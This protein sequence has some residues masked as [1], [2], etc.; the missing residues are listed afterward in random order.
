MSQRSCCMYSSS[1]VSVT[2]THMAPFL[3]IIWIVLSPELGL[4]PN[5]FLS[6]GS[7]LSLSLLKSFSFFSPLFTTSNFLSL[8]VHRAKLMYCCFLWALMTGGEKTRDFFKPFGTPQPQVSAGLS[9]LES[10]LLK[11]GK[12]KDLMVPQTLWNDVFVIDSQTNS[13]KPRGANP[14]LI[15]SKENS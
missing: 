13:V 5:L 14:L 10:V 9:M 6:I 7:H 3:H 11:S 12:K 8:W 15:C 4:S 2:S 1:L